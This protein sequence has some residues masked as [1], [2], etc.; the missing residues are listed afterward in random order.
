MVQGFIE[1][2][3]FPYGRLPS[4]DVDKHYDGSPSNLAPAHF[5]LSRALPSVDVD[6]HQDGSPGKNKIRSAL[7][8]LSVFCS[9]GTKMAASSEGTTHLVDEMEKAF[10]VDNLYE[11]NPQ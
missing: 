1:I 8:N 5:F 11:L 7:I 10:Q 9:Y 4:V 6:K 2:A 3:C